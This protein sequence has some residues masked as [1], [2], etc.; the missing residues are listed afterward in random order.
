MA[1]GPHHTDIA[2]A[3]SALPTGEDGETDGLDHQSTVL[4]LHQSGG[5]FVIAKSLFANKPRIC[6][7]K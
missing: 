6:W 1:P 2:P 7:L 5:N 3:M 4:G